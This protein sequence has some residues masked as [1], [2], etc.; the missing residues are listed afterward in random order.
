M[1]IAVFLF[2]LLVAQQYPIQQ[3]GPIQAPK[4]P[5]LTPGQIQKPGPIQKP[6]QIQIPRGIQAIKTT[7]QS[8]GKKYT[9]GSDALFA[10]DK[11]TLSPDAEKTLGVL[12]PMLE[13]SAHQPIHIVGYTDAIGSVDYNITLSEERAKTVRDWLAAHR[14]I[15]AS[16]PYVGRGKADPVAPN[17]KPDGSDNPLGR[18]KNRRV[19]ITVGTC[20]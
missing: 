11:Y 12:G 8:C 7:T 16:T 1:N 20:R 15:P 10:F 13:K 18:Q 17:T 6:G 5:W 2:T 19:E 4:G 9:V 3:P 14:Y